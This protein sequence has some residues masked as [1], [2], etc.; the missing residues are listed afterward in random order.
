MKKL[1]KIIMLYSFL[2]LFS[3][4]NVK[5][6][7]ASEQFYE[8]NQNGVLTIKYNNTQNLKMKV[9]VIK[10]AK[11]YYYNLKNGL[12]ELD[13]PLTMGN[14][15]YKLNI[16]KNVSGTKYSLVK[17][18][19]YELKLEDENKVFL[20]SNV[21]VNYKSEDKPIQKAE[22]LT[23]KSITDFDKVEDIYE[24]VVK[25]YLYDYDKLVNLVS[26]YIPDINLVYKNKKGICYDISTLVA[27]MMRSQGVPVKVV[28][29]Y[30]PNI[31][32]Y[33][34]WNLIYD[35]EKDQWITVD[36]TYDLSM[37]V[38]GKKF[39]MAK[40]TKDYEDIVYLY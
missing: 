29:G 10:D 32:A 30:T 1:Q 14:G 18:N 2:I 23:K 21:I 17:S 24:Y 3:L 20:H 4:F 26:G 5:N 33:H 19:T 7:S 22:T 25:N 39:K 12:N 40:P 8:D 36:A 6:V 28:T 11:T 38:A 34:A 35:E 37:Y 16:Y 9:A 31:E 27:A 15:N 13:I